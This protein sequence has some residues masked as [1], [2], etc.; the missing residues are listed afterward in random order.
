MAAT[1]VGLADTAPIA[2]EQYAAAQDAA[3]RCAFVAEGARRTSQPL[4]A[5]TRLAQAN[6]IGNVH[7]VHASSSE[8]WRE[9][10][11]WP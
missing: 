7:E 10:R 3:F 11:A 5:T 6:A 4:L 8:G 9:G 1:S 2:Y